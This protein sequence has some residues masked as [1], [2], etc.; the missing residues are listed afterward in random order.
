MFLKVVNIPHS[1]PMHPRRLQQLQGCATAT[2]WN[3]WWA[4]SQ[5]PCEAAKISCIH[6]QG[7]WS[8]SI[9]WATENTWI[10]FLLQSLISLNGY[11]E[12]C[13]HQEH[14]SMDTNLVLWFWSGSSLLIPWFFNHS[15]IL[16]VSKLQVFWESAICNRSRYKYANTEGCP[17]PFFKGQEEKACMEGKEEK[18]VKLCSG[19][20]KYQ[21][22]SVWWY[23]NSRD[24]TKL[25]E[26]MSHSLT[27]YLWRGPWPH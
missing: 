3:S 26:T 27:F 4:G 6:D 2:W 22:Y 25:K 24:N 1:L 7:D 8:I 17:Y 9:I 19:R 16:W 18:Q 11:S 5:L 14:F 10:H 21:Q 12:P 23:L 13:S 15:F 20:V